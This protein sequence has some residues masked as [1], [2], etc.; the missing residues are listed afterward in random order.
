VELAHAFLAEDEAGF[1]NA[2]LDRLAGQVRPG[3]T[4]GAGSS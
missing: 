3:G 2:L 4:A 1:V